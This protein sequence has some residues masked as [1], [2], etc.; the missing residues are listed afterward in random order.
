ML[1]LILHLWEA[2]AVTVHLPAAAV[3]A[4]E[5]AEAAEAPDT[6]AAAPHVPLAELPEN[7]LPVKV[8][9][10]SFTKTP[11][12]TSEN[13]L[14]QLIRAPYAKV[15]ASAVFVTAPVELDRG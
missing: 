6:A 12:D 7:V 13:T 15:A 5:A 8:K 11:A 9:E 14:I 2:Q 1:V 10:D 3:T 4:A